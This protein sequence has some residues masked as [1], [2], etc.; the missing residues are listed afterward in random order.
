VI[1]WYQERL[2]KWNDEL[3]TE[4]AGYVKSIFAA[5]M[6]KEMDRLSPSWDFSQPTEIIDNLAAILRQAEG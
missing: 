3:A 6:D 2:D 4:A 5:G 1:A